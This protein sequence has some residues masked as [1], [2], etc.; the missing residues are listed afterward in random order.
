MD[1]DSED[2]VQEPSPFSVIKVTINRDVFLRDRE[3]YLRFKAWVR[4]HHPNA[5]VID[6]KAEEAF[7]EF[8]IFFSSIPRNFHVELYLKDR[9]LYLELVKEFPEVL[10]GADES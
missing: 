6:K 3:Y 1:D 4:K 5:F 7:D 8:D 10:R 9:E 2:I